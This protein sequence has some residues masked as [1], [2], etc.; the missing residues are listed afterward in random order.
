M[1]DNVKPSEA[2]SPTG[3]SEGWRVAYE[4]SQTARL[5]RLADEAD[6]LKC[7]VD[8]GG[9]SLDGRFSLLFG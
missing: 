9:L 8:L 6:L 2:T 3:K 7:G 5:E 1:N 4:E